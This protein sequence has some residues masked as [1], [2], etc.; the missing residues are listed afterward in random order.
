MES[1]RVSWCSA[2]IALPV[3]GPA[4]CLHGGVGCTTG[5]PRLGCFCSQGT[6]WMEAVLPTRQKQCFPQDT[7]TVFLRVG[8]R[9]DRVQPEF[10]LGG[11]GG[12]QT[13]VLMLN[14]ISVCPGWVGLKDPRKS[15]ERAKKDT[16]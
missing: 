4:P 6:V 5:G 16:W 10:L 15:Q 13:A 12:K 9:E 7:S 1:P 2:L 8:Y 11:K 14:C 3:W